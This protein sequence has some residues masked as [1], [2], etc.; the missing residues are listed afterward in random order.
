MARFFFHLR[1]AGKS[2]ADDQ[3]AVFP[4]DEAARAEA[5]RIV[6]NFIDPMSGRVM[7]EW[8]EWSLDLCDQRGRSVLK[9]DF[10]QATLDAVEGLIPDQPSG[11]DA[12]P[13]EPAVELPGMSLQVRRASSD[14]AESA[15][16]VRSATEILRDMIA[17]SQILQEESRWILKRSRAQTKPDS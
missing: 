1:C 13:P 16:R 17:R 2:M 7:S 8:Q 6:R 12:T 11:A 3:T 14:A 10:S 5:R 9:I 15:R 4:N